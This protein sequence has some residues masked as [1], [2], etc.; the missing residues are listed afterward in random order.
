VAMVVQVV[1]VVQIVGQVYSGTTPK[2]Y[3]ENG[4]TRYVACDWLV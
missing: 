4:V 2:L 3:S 1:Q